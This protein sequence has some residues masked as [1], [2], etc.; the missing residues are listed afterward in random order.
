MPYKF[1][2]QSLDYSDY[3]SGRVLYNL[4]GHPAFPVRL[5]SEIFQRCLAYRQEVSPNTA[6]LTLY[7]PCCG[8]AYHLAV[9]G[10]L[11]GEHIQK[12]IASDVDDNA[13]EVAKRNL[14]LLSPAGLEQR[15]GEINEMITQY[16]KDSHKAALASAQ[17]IKAAQTASIPARVF[18]ANALESNAL[19][20]QI[21]P[22]SIDIVFTDVPYG[23][24]SQWLG[25]SPAARQN[26]LAAL[27]EALHPLLAPNSIIAIA[28]DKQQK[29]SHP[30]Y[31]RVERFQI[32][33][34]RI[35][36]LTLI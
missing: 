7:D 15:I 30:K 33:K 19:L 26:P 11:H 28:T 35:E 4:P 29:A 36:L 31:Q 24:H 6:P 9:L 8:A 1:A 25:L 3:S 16:D 32:G 34:R 5:A 20:A 22:S 17:R 18:Q 13:V 21:P 14:G 23:Q 10:F 2:T 12:I 27:L